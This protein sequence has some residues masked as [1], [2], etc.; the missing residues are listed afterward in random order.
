MSRFEFDVDQICSEIEGRRAL[1][2]IAADCGVS[3]QT[4]SLVAKQCRDRR[5]DTTTANDHWAKV[6]RMSGPGNA[7]HVK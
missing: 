6:Q 4:I 1:A 3:P 5:P 7:A 2:S